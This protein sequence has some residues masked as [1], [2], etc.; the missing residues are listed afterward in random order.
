MI[1]LP[2]GLKSL[3]N[4]GGVPVTGPV[5]VGNFS[6]YKADLGAW[7]LCFGNQ[8]PCI[9][10]KGSQFVTLPTDVLIAQ[11]HKTCLQEGWLNIPILIFVDGE[12]PALEVGL[13]Q[14]K[15]RFIL[16]DEKAQAEMET[17]VSPKEIIFEQARRWRSL[18]EMSPYETKKPVTGSAFFGRHEE[19]EK[20]VRN[21]H[22]SYLFVGIHRMGKTSLLKQMKRRL[23]MVD[24]PRTGQ[25]RRVYI[26]CTV[27]TT[28][29]DFIKTLVSQ[30][31]QS[32]FTLVSRLNINPEQYQAEILSHYAH[33]HGGP[34]TFL[35]DE[36]DR[37]LSHI[38]RN[39]QLLDM[40]KKALAE[41]HI[42][43]IA[44]GYR[45][46]IDAMANEQSTFYSILTPVWLKP[47]TQTAVEQMVL[48]PLT[49][50][51]ITVAEPTQFI[52]YIRHET[53]SLP[54]YVQYYCRALLEYAEAQNKTVLTIADL[55]IVP[56]NEKFRSFL[57]NSF[58]SNTDL[59]EQAIIY[60]MI[61][62]NIEAIERT[63]AIPTVD[64][65]LQK[66]GLTLTHEQIEAACQNLNLSGVFNQ[67]E[68]RYK[69]AIRQF[70]DILA[71]ER[72]VEFLFARAREALQTEKIL[73]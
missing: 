35:L 46:A 39:W 2:I 58:M 22:T 21:P 64:M 1:E 20:V 55:N 71:Q 41:K 25:V 19:I 65:L 40:I 5:Q 48:I 56:E 44:A 66:R 70:K 61:S 18:V 27:I 4:K 13:K 62:E 28:E 69:F 12:G 42:R 52:E 23:D 50:L 32:G 10:V 14:W 33:I 8:T 59:I 68:T 63:Q 9:W 54:N 30:L 7:R 53:S 31:E 47:L 26:D 73:A 11:L 3:V 29:E 34:I 37:L 36:F 38:N 67:E 6:V 15:S 24:P 51:G 60:A 72:D 57:L 45:N 16:I 43:I 49:Q 17:A